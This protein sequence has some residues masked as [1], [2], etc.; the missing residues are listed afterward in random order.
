MKKVLLILLIL[1]LILAGCSAGKDSKNND[2]SNAVN[3]VDNQDPQNTADNQ[4][5]GDSDNNQSPK[6]PDNVQIPVNVGMTSDTVIHRN[7]DL[8]V[9]KPGEKEIYESFKKS[10][11]NELLRGLEPIVVANFY[12]YASIT[13]D[14]ETQY[15]LYIDDEN[16]IQWSKE[17]HLSFPPDPQESLSEYVLSFKNADLYFAF[18]TGDENSGYVSIVDKPFPYILMT[19]NSAGIWKINFLPGQ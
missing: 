6:N 4:N 11:D 14:R 18:P 15:E 1:C 7:A 10:Y 5:P 2:Q 13:G 17:H 19:K 8:T 3:P 12:I 16:H 9:L